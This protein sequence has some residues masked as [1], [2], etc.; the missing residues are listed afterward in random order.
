MT[1]PCNTLDVQ[2]LKVSELTNYES[3]K[4]NDLIYTIESGS[5]DTKYSRHS[6]L[7]DIKNYMSTGSYTGSFVGELEGNV[8]GN[9]TGDLIGNVTGDIY[10]DTSKLTLQNSSDEPKDSHF[11][12]TSSFSLNSQNS[13]NSLTSSYVLLSTSASYSEY[14]NS[15]SHALYSDESMS[16]SYS[17]TS[18]YSTTSSFSEYADTAK[19]LTDGKVIL[20]S[21]FFTTKNDILESSNTFNSSITVAPTYYLVNLDTPASD[22]NYS[23]MVTVNY[24]EYPYTIENSIKTAPWFDVTSKTNELFTFIPR[25][26]YITNRTCRDCRDLGQGPIPNYETYGL[27]GSYVVIQN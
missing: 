14:T 21:G 15:S 6:K 7:S 4:D 3:L 9:V 12:G 2:Y 22:A 5:G 10:S 26:T 16:S 27:T 18:S 13:L 1:T 24:S 17:L 8:T 25:G 11:Y 19:S 20:A 23:L